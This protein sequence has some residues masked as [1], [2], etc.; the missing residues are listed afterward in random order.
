MYGLN[1]AVFQSI[2]PK[3]VRRL[4]T[5]WYRND[6]ILNFVWAVDVKFPSITMW[7]DTG[8]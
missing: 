4:E 6:T 3:T 5:V 1:L 2:H 8:Q 7:L